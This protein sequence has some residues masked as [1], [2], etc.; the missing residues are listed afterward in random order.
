MPEVGKI[1]LALRVGIFA[2]TGILTLQLVSWALNWAGILV[3]AAMAVFASAAVANALTL[4]IF[5]RGG[6][7]DIG[8]G[9]RIGSLKNLSFGVAGGMVSALA[10]TGLPVL[11]GMASV[12]NDPEHGFSASSLLFVSMVMIFGAVGEELLFHGYAFQLL[13]RKMG[14][15]STLLP[16]GVLFAAAHANNLNANWMSFFNTFLWGVFLG[17]CFLRSGDLWLPIGVHFG[18]N[19]ALPLL[20]SNVSGFKMV[21]TGLVMNWNAGPLWSG[22]EYGP[23]AGLLTTLVLPV[24][25]WCL[26]KA[27]I[28][29]ERPQMFQEEE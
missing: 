10:V 17:L 20:G 16:V 21:T 5:E 6:I 7:S 19:W 23:E 18:W 22:G 1:G 8:L 26:F 14:A 4:K 3:Q 12:S 13:L 28:E 9:W 15:F 24:L 29:T 25:G 11:V 2:I 27:P